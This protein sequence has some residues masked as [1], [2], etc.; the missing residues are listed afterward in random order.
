MIAG[1]R[2]LLD[3]AVSAGELVPCNTAAL[4]RAVGAMSGGSLIAWAI[5]RQGSAG[6][7]VRRDLETL[8]GPYR[9]A[10]A[11]GSVRT[12]RSRATAAATRR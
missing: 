4:A 8:V 3:E 12:G 5:H 6:R 9:P 7:W 10:S 2:A 1:Y 11:G